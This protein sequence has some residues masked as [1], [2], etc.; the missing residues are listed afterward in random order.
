VIVHV[1]PC[2]D[3]LCERCLQAQCQDRSQAG[4]TTVQS[5]LVEEV[6]LKRE[7]RGK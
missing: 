7:D 5:W 4:T 1:D 2:E 3:P 6:V